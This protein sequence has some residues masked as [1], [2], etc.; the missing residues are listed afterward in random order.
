[1]FFVLAVLGGTLLLREQLED[2]LRRLWW[3]SLGPLVVQ[4]WQGGPARVEGTSFG[5][6]AAPTLVQVSLGAEFRPVMFQ[7]P[8]ASM[9]VVLDG[10]RSLVFEEAAGRRYGTFRFANGSSYGFVLYE[11]GEDTLLAVDLDGN[12]DFGDDGP[13][14]ESPTD[15]FE[16][17]VA[18]PMRE[19]SGLN[20][21]S[22]YHLW[23]Y[24]TPEGGLR[25]VALTQLAGEVSLDGRS[26][27]AF[28]VENTSID[29]DYTNE[30]IFVD[31]NVDGRLNAATEYVAPGASLEFETGGFEFLVQQ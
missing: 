19:V 7:I 24:R 11:R 31:W 30:G 14:Y 8:A 10:N 3:G 6:I 29:G 27:P 15:A 5:G 4:D 22:A 28:V 16:V 17:T 26:Y 13:P 21:D 23:L 25:Q 20:L 9:P 12:R 1:M 2:P 18:L